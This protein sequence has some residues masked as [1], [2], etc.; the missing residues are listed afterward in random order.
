MPREIA[1][2]LRGRAC[3][4]RRIDGA[5]GIQY[6]SGMRH[7]MSKTATTRVTVKRGEAPPR[8]KTNWKRLA[9]MTDRD[10]TDAARSDPDSQ[11]LTRSQLSRMR[12]VPRVKL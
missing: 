6:R 1:N 10:V 4:P 3:S 5:T 12:R 11:P 8:G 7:A 9:A 2:P